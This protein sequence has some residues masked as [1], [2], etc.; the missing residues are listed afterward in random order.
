MGVV[1]Q[2]S[3][4]IS[5][6]SDAGLTWRTLNIDAGPLAAGVGGLVYA[7][8]PTPGASLLYVSRDGGS[9]WTNVVETENT[10]F[11]VTID[12]FHASTAFRVDFSIPGFGPAFTSLW[13]TSDAGATWSRVD[14]GLG[15]SLGGGPY[16]SAFAADPRTTDVFYA[17]VGNSSFLQPPFV[18]AKIYVT[19]DGGSTWSLIQSSM[20]GTVQSLA[21]DPFSS[22]TLYAG[23]VPNITGLGSAGLLKSID[24]GNTFRLINNAP[25]TSITMDPVRPGHVY[26]L[27]SAGV[28]ASSDGGAT[29]TSMNTGLPVPLAV[30]SLAVDPRGEFLYAASGSVFEYTLPLFSCNA[31]S[32]TLCLNEGRFAVTVDFQTT[33]E[34]PSSPATAVPL[35]ADTGYFW[36]FDPT[37]VEVVTKVL[38]GCSTNG[39]YWFF[40]GSLTNVGVE[41]NVT[42]TLT[43][44]SKPYSNAVGS[45]FPPIQDTAAFPCP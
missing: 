42:D 4:Q 21:V 39:H 32:H 19:R 26:F 8:F 36:F 35:T 38:N 31:D 20:G 28:H 14:E 43:G 37:N 6:S 29:W 23:I 3:P 9:T 13:R 12:P 1:G 44:A 24:R 15:T 45:A 5:K 7:G 30:Y 33:P 16:V 17:A 25:A 18:A 10:T 2:G 41:I 22:S 11:S 27:A 40:A 34:G